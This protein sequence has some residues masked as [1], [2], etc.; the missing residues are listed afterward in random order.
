MMLSKQPHH[1][2]MY[3]LLYGMTGAHSIH[4]SILY[5][6]NF[7]R[8]H[9]TCLKKSLITGS[10]NPCPPPSLILV[11]KYRRTFSSSLVEKYEYNSSPANSNPQAERGKGKGGP[12]PL[13]PWGRTALAGLCG[14]LCCLIRIINK[15]IYMMMMVV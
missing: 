3:I 2:S 12:W 15:S 1:Y 11:R 9:D 8:S 6:V 10:E 7:H 14:V 13:G 5:M 4:R